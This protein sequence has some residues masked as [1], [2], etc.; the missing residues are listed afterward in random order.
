MTDIFLKTGGFLLTILAG[1]LFKRIGILKASD[2]AVLRK[3]ML[4]LTL[5]CVLAG[6]VQNMNLQA[7]LLVPLIAGFIVAPVA[8]AFCHLVTRKKDKLTQAMYMLHLASF[9]VA[10]VSVPF[11]SAFMPA[12]ALSISSIFDIGNAIYGTGGV[13]AYACCHVDSDKKFRIRDVLNSVRK[14]TP[15]MIYVPLLLLFL[16]GV[17][18]PDGFYTLL[19]TFGSSN[20]FLAFFIIGMMIDFK[21]EKQDLGEILRALAL[22]YVFLIPVLGLIWLLPI[23]LMV[24]Q[25]LILSLLA[26]FSAVATAFCANLGCKPQQTGMLN[27]LS[28]F[29]SMAATVLMMILWGI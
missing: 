10:S 27:T 4:N 7:D 22:R 3:I 23:D 2:A 29:T 21:L 12:A 19:K 11:I 25:V 24:R 8:I 20:S 28:I 26:P 14:S 18:L 1:Y 5:P 17:R 6:S 13:Y 16:C 15:L 9:N